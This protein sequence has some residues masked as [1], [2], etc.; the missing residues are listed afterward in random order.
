[1]EQAGGDP[2]RFDIRWLGAIHALLFA[3]FYVA[4]LVLLRPLSAV[5]RIVLSLAALW[6]FADVGLVSYF[7]SFYSDVPAI[8]GGLT[9]AVLAVHLMTSQKIRM[10]LLVLFGLASLMFVTSKGQH[11]ILGLVPLGAALAIGWRSRDR[12]TRL[13]GCVISL[14]LTAGMLWVFAATPA[15]FAAQAK[16][17]LIFTKIARNSRTPLQDL[18]ALGLEDRDLRYVGMH[19]YLPDSP[20][21]DTQWRDGFN[22]RSSYSQVL[23]FYSRHPYRTLA[24]LWSDLQ[25]EA[26]RRRVFANFPKSYGRPP[27]AQTDRL[28]SWSSMRS[29]LFAKCPAHI[30][31]WYGLAL[32]APP[33]LARYEKSRFQRSLLWMIAA[34][35]VL[36]A[37]EFGVS[38]LAD[39]VETFRHLLMFHVFTD[40]AIFL[41]LV[42]VAGR[43]SRRQPAPTPS[44][45]P[46]PQSP[47]PIPSPGEQTRGPY[48]ASLHSGS[49]TTMFCQLRPRIPR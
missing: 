2:T 4:V 6:I 34:L 23:G 3:G 30:L 1:L 45:S 35:S 21:Q 9:A 8:L 12:Y 42:L 44:P 37:L 11:A 14:A 19:A 29:W 22:A 40:A 5:A 31:L 33:L 48:L 41:A 10:G 17:N 46:Q 18:R 36:G 26:P 38:S 13:A 32:L 47:A 16:F 25:A 15:W 20:M 7:N 43:L 28:S 49:P 27:G 39:G 24:I